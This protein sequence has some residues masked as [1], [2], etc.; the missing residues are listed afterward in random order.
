MFKNRLMSK[1]TVIMS[2]MVVLSSLNAFAFDATKKIYTA[3]DAK[4]DQIYYQA[5]G[6]TI[7]KNVDDATRAN[8]PY[9]KDEKE[10]ATEES[11]KKMFIDEWVNSGLE[12]K[13]GITL[14]EVKEA[15]KDYDILIGISSTLWD[16]RKSST[17]VR[18]TI[19]I[20]YQMED[21]EH[22]LQNIAESYRVQARLGLLNAVLS[23]NTRSSLFYEADA[24]F[25]AKRLSSDKYDAS[26]LKINPNIKMSDIKTE[27]VVEG[28]IAV[29]GAREYFDKTKVTEGTFGGG[30][31]GE[32]NWYERQN[33]LREAFGNSQD[34]IDGDIFAYNACSGFYYKEFDE[35]FPKILESIPHAKTEEEKENLRKKFRSYE[36]IMEKDY[37][38]MVKNADNHVAQ[39][40]GIDE[41]DTEYLEPENKKYVRAFAEA[42]NKEYNLRKKG[43]DVLSVRKETEKALADLV[44]HALEQAEKLSPNDKWENNRRNDV[45]YGIGYMI[46]LLYYSRTNKEFEFE[47]RVNNRVGDILTE[48]GWDAG[49][50]FLLRE[51]GYT[52]SNR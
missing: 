15:I 39:Y 38:R 27:A 31:F 37:N 8:R 9:L 24:L 40:F 11:F 20:E 49:K 41:G 45:L 35:N 16:G 21:K 22:Y 1:K 33:N 14:Q 2:A 12:K 18:K 5:R 51:V 32:P 19:L 44:N 50:R 46:D 4:A 28:I 52:K 7:F 10:K 43:L 17:Y 25:I 47:Q 13:T 29:M 34:I 6:T 42:C 36:E 23:S 26:V 30:V 48:E 3:E